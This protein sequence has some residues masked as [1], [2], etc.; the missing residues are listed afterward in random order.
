MDTSEHADDAGA[1]PAAPQ[2]NEPAHSG[3]SVDGGDEN[4]R[5][6]VS[7]RRHARRRRQLARLTGQ[8]QAPTKWHG[9]TLHEKLLILLESVVLKQDLRATCGFARCLT[10]PKERKGRC[11]RS[12]TPLCSRCA[13]VRR[14]RSMSRPERL[15]VRERAL[16]GG[17]PTS[18]RMRMEHETDLARPQSLSSRACCKAALRAYILEFF[19]RRQPQS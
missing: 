9:R 7:S 14:V 15:P 16:P 19:R 17:A 12:N 11:D 6:G 5:R 4:R 10:Q 13:L 18:A 3:G 8:C 2:Q 1:D